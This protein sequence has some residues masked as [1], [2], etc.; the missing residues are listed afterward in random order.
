MVGKDIL[1][2]HAVYWPAML[3]AAGLPL[4]KCV[5]AHGWLLVGGEKM[6]KTKLTGIA[7]SQIVDYVGSDA[8]RYYFLS[9]IK[10]GQDG[11]FSWEDLTARY[12]AELANGLGN[13]ASRLTA[14]VEKYF[15]KQLPTPGEFNEADKKLIELAKSAAKAAD[16]AMV[17]LDFSTG[18]NQIRSIVDATNLYLTEQEPWKVAKDPAQN[19]RLATILYVVAELLRIIAV[20]Y[21]PVMP[22]S[23]Q[24][25]WRS[26]GA[27]KTL[28][29][30]ASQLISTTFEF[31]K[32]PQGAL[33]SKGESLFPQLLEDE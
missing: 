15:E 10:F 1:R 26:L 11:S 28:G 29:D 21:Y 12:K 25:L 4:P 23:S 8:F 17:L 18:I 31:G 22:K 16:Q 20:L 2:F 19:E 7:P 6:S 33:T 32:L 14:M 5:F 27:E 13:L 3:L 30:L 9:A 24:K